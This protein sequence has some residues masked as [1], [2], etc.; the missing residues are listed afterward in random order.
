MTLPAIRTARLFLNPV[1]ERDIESLHRLWT[2]PGVRRYLWDDV[3]ISRERA[4]EAARQ[5]IAYWTLRVVEDGEVMG[6]CGF[7]AID[8]S[9]EVELMYALLPS[10]WGRGLATEA[11]QA[12]LD[13]VW[14]N[15]RHN[16]VFART[17]PPNAKSVGVMRRLGMRHE[18]ATATMITYVIERS[19]Q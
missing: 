9:P 19:I 3:V 7:R 2:N 17:N 5:G 4:A 10:Y 16:R 8:D 14:S 6:F 12:V 18:R 15:T 11:S 13:Y 1:D